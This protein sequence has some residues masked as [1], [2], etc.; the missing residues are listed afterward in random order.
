MAGL[1][2]TIIVGTKLKELG[3]NNFRLGRSEYLVLEADEYARSFHNYFPKIAVLT[4]IDK[5]HLDVYKNL[6]GVI[7]G[8]RKYLGNVSADG[9]VVE[10][11]KDKNI[12]KVINPKPQNPKPKKN[13]KSK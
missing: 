6:N 7:A 1:D 8:F 13:S 3:G 11:K 9:Y 12:Q 10:N 2:P 4:N 5:E